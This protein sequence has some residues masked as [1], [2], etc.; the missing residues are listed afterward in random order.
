MEGRRVFVWPRRWACLGVVLATACNEGPTPPPVPARL[1]LVT[2]PAATAQSGVALL[3]Q[4]LVQ[5]ADR[6]GRSIRLGGVLVTVSIATGGG[7]IGGVTSIPS[8]SAGRAVFTDLTI[9]GLVGPR[10]LQFSSTGLTVAMSGTILVTP[11]PPSQL[12]LTTEPADAAQ[13]GIPFARQPVVQLR[14]AA[15]NDAPLSGVAVAPS[16]VGGGGGLAPV[17]PVP[18]NAAGQAVFTALAI[19]GTVGTW[20]LRFSAANL[21]PTTSAAIALS[22]GPASRLVV[23]GQPGFTSQS[24]VPFT[25]QPV[26]Q[27][28]DAAGNDVD[29]SGVPVTPGIAT[30]SGTLSD[31][32]PVL[33]DARGEAAFGNLAITGTGAHTLRF[34]AP[35]LAS[36]TSTTIYIGTVASCADTMPGDA[37]GDRLPDCVETHTGVFLSPLDTGTDPDNPDTDGDAINDGDEVLGTVLGL[38]LPGMGVSPLRKN[39]LIEYDWFDDALECSPHSHRP[40]MTA[41]GMVAAAFAGAPVLNPDGSTGITVIQDYGQGGAFTGGNLIGDLDGV[42]SGGV[43]DA[44]FHNHKLN[45]FTPNRNGYFHYTILPHRYNTNS[46]SSGQAEL[47][48]DDQIVSLYCVAFDAYVAHTIMH[49]LGHNLYL[50]HGGFESS[51]W[52]PNYNSVMNYRYQFAGIDDDCTPPGNGI[53]NYSVGTRPPLDENNLDEAR[54]VCGNPPGPG[55]DWNGDGDAVDVGIAADINTDFSGYGDG[56]LWTLQDYNDWASLFWGGLADADVSGARLVAKQI[57]SCR[58]APIGR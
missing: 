2:P 25:P 5:L 15:G 41:A 13:S 39:I 22:P 27:V 33:T 18:T 30:G 34:S 36:A 47:P 58:D 51:N 16:I 21:T 57:I 56:W 43:D 38:D 14:D 54:G 4:P 45:N 12:V 29:L 8:D 28:R 48:G 53:L 17:A 10:T 49:E 37:D 1:S 42:L 35:G 32:T 3:Q 26:V 50:Q 46:G 55:W 6:H 24:G 9:S 44:E 20:T 7:T 19:T 40:T 52:K 11:G 23:T 31:L